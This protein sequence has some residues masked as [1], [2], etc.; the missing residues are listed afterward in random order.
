MPDPTEAD[1][2]A[3]RTAAELC[4]VSAH[5]LLT[6]VDPMAWFLFRES[7]GLPEVREGREF[8]L[9]WFI[10]GLCNA[11]GQAEGILEPVEDHLI[12][13]S[14]GIQQAG[15]VTEN[16]AHA[17]AVGYAGSL[18]REI[19]YECRGPGLLD[20]GDD[21]YFDYDAHADVV[22]AKTGRITRKLL[23][24]EPFDFDLVLKAIHLESIKAIDRLEEPPGEPRPEPPVR[25]GGP[26]ELPQIR[27]AK[28]PLLNEQQYKV[29]RALLDVWPKGL[30]GDKLWRVAGVGD[31]VG[32]LRR[33]RKLT[34]WES[35]IIFPGDDGGGYRI[36]Q[37]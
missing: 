18:W 22:L 33:L 31:A 35:A 1:F 14:S 8:D 7:G 10:H 5:L 13:V 16:N 28:V 4:A 36:A 37:H 29:I 17:L 2:I 11:L 6:R 9:P 12:L 24:R 20:I 3:A 23:E 26:D 34:E 15:G 27:G 30:S 21:Q 19:L 32:I 25:L